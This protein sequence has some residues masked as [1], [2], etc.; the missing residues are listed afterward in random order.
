MFL[1]GLAT[2]LFLSSMLAAI[3]WPVFVTR[4]QVREM[5]DADES[6]RQRDADRFDRN[7]ELAEIP[8][9][10]RSRRGPEGLN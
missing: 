7:A 5:L 1:A 3:V 8:D 2:G 10:V 9:T 4:I 6:A